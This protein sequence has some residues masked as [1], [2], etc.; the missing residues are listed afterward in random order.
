[1]KICQN[2]G[3]RYEDER[4]VCPYCGA[5]DR[6]LSKRQYREKI[7]RLRKQRQD[8]RSLPKMIPRKAVK[9]LGIGV[10]VAVALFA[11]A[12]VVL[13]IV[14]NIRK[15]GAQRLEEKNIALMEEY[16]Q[17]EQFQELYDFYKELPYTYAR[18]DKYKEVADVYYFYTVLERDLEWYQQALENS[19]EE[20]VSEYRRD[21]LKALKQLRD[22]VTEREDDQS[23]MGNESFLRRIYE[24]GLDE[25]CGA[26]SLEREEAEDLLSE[27]F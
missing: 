16:L 27:S 2:C 5:E 1:M 9:V 15:S 24:M 4:T 8:I 23:R 18:Y 3:A 22:E 19:S 7:N 20:F 25:V 12:L 14:Q 21:L 26:L 17:N 11:L 13:L 10:I 6:K